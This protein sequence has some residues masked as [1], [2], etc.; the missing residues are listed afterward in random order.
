LPFGDEI[1]LVN[2]GFNSGYNKIYGMWR[3]YGT[4]QTEKQRIVP[5]HPTDLVDFAGKGKYH[6]LNLLGLGK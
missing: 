2:P 1:N 6:P 4:D 5:L 3:G